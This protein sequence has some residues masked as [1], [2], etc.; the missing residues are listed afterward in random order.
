MRSLQY[1]KLGVGLETTE[2]SLVAYGAGNW[3]RK[4]R[5][6]EREKG[7]RDREKMILIWSLSCAQIS[8]SCEGSLHSQFRKTVVILICLNFNNPKPSLTTH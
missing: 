3:A 4:Q 6:R 2:T 8:S 5:E 7:E 1:R